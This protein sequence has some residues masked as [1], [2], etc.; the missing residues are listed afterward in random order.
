[1]VKTWSSSKDN[2]KTR[3]ASPKK[4]AQYLVGCKRHNILGAASGKTTVNATRYRAQLNKVEAEVINRSLNN[5]KIYFQH[6][7]AKPHVAKIVKEK[8]EKF[9]WEL[10]THP[11]YSP[12]LTPSDYHLFR[13]LSNDMRGKMFKE[14][15]DLKSYLQAFFDLKSEEFNASGIYDLPR[16]W[17]E[18][19]CTNGEYIID[20]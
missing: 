13:S 19:I 3:F 18:V 1:M 10:L 4:N 9:G 6:D 16:R 15:K 17:R 2:T 11:P 14:E 8:I 7:N 20:K 5:G 12:D